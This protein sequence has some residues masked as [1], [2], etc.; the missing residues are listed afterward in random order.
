MVGNAEISNRKVEDP[1]NCVGFV[2]I[3]SGPSGAGKGTVIVKMREFRDDFVLSISTTTRPPREGAVGEHYQHVGLEEF[4]QLVAEGA[5]LEWA[6]VHGNLYGTRKQW[7]EEK[8]RE[9]WIVVLE[10]DVQGALQVMQRKVDNASVFITPSDR[11]IAHE[12]LRARGTES[13]EGYRAKDSQFGMGIFTDE[14][15]R[16]YC[17]ERF[18]KAGRSGEGAVVDF[19]R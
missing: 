10:I 3:V 2:V 12:R 5:F 13:S 11:E 9:G 8:V 14:P 17:A 19:N 18:R 16:L 15:V 1:P 7:V 4:H 6:E